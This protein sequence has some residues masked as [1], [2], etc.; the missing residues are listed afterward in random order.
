M[1]CSL[2][3]APPSKIRGGRGGLHFTRGTPEGPAFEGL[4]GVTPDRAETA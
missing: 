2:Q 1:S 4:R 3:V